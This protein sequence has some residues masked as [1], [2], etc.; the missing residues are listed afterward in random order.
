MHLLEETVPQNYTLASGRIALTSALANQQSKWLVVI[1]LTQIVGLF[2]L[3][4]KVWKDQHLSS[5]LLSY[6]WGNVQVCQ[7]D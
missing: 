4:P 2:F 5:E 6:Y 7:A 1:N 3:T